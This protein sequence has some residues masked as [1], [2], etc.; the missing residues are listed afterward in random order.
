MPNH[1][2]NYR[3]SAILSI[4]MI[5]A[6]TAPAVAG[7]VATFLNLGFSE[8]SKTFMFGQYGIDKETSFP[9]AESYIVDV[10]KNEFVARGTTRFM[11]DTVAQ[12]GQDGIGA[13]FNLTGAQHEISD[14]YGIDHLLMGRLVYLYI[15]GSEPKHEIQFRDFNTGKRYTISLIQSVRD[16]EIPEAAFHINLNSEDKDG[17]RHVRT[18]GL[19][20]YY[21]KNINN[22]NIRQIL[23]S[24]D[25][26]SVII[27]IEKM[28]DTEEGRYLRYM[29]ETTHLYN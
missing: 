3:K 20:N 11:A 1:M 9:Y 27:V 24:P 13:L 22:Y 17:E 16:G 15:N 23:L 18:M 14:S 6:I 4:A 2:R 28:L 19:P 21:R 5:A 29:V 12:P 8:D 26:K 25:E 10:E 7:D